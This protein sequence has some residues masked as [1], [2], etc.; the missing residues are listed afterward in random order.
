METSIIGQASYY[1]VTKVEREKKL[2]PLCV[3]LSFHIRYSPLTL[4]L[5]SPMQ[6]TPKALPKPPQL[7]KVCNTIISFLVSIKKTK[8]G[9]LFE[10]SQRTAQIVRGFPSPQQ[11]YEIHLICLDRLCAKALSF[12]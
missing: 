6:S 7:F 1:H 5:P 12:Y 11:F 8:L 10:M 4:L 9:T 2:Y 3:I